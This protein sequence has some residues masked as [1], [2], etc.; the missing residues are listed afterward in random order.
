MSNQKGAS[1]YLQCSVFHNQLS[2]FLNYYQS[3]CFLQINNCCFKIMKSQP[4]II[5]IT[6]LMLLTT[7]NDFEKATTLPGLMSSHNLSQINISNYTL[8]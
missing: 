5:Y 4:E 3:V 2:L 1:K 8:I 7:M 6:I